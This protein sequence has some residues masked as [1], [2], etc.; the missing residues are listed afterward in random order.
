MGA[1]HF[2]RSTK[3]ILESILAM[4]LNRHGTRRRRR[5]SS[6]HFFPL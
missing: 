6:G 5:S 2:Y 1:T 3:E 4:Q